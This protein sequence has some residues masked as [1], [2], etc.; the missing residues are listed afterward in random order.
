MR[1]YIYFISFFFSVTLSAQSSIPQVL[2]KLNKGTIPYVK[3]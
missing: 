2:K 1:L 3:K